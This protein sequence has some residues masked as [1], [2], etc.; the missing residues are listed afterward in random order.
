MDETQTLKPGN[1]LLHSSLPCPRFA[2]LLSL[3]YMMHALLL[4]EHLLWATTRDSGRGCRD[5]QFEPICAYEAA[6]ACTVSNP[7]FVLP[8]QQDEGSAGA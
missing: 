2:Q 8:L 3:G 4:P 5:L 1:T 7:A 6:P